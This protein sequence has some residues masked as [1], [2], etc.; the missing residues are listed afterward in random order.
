MLYDSID[1][2]SHLLDKID[3]DPLVDT[4]LHI[5]AQHGQIPFARE[6]MMLNPS[7]TRK[8]NRKGHNTMHLA[9]YSKKTDMVL[10]F[11]NCEPGLVRIK[12]RVGETPLHYLVKKG[13][14]LEHQ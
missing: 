4:P 1:K 13:E 9:L 8:L 7:F 6:I 12:G 10:E 3:K 14:D 11:Q 5:A 2:D